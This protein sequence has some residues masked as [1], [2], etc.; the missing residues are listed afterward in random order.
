[1]IEQLI[2]W[3]QELFLYL[4]GLGTTVWDAFWLTYTA[5]LHW[6]PF[7]A[8]LAYL[9]FKRLN[10]KMFVLTLVV[11]TLMISFT[12]QGTNFFKDLFERPRPCYQDGVKEIMRL[13][14]NTCGG[15]NSY[16]SGHSSNAMSLAIFVGLVMRKKYKF[17]IYGMIVW[18]LLMGYSRIYIGVHYPLDVI[19]GFLF[20]GLAGLGF[21]KLDKYIQSRYTIVERDEEKI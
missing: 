7:Y 17:M 9:L 8:I 21:Y 15:R 12:D 16:F 6:I 1:M 13:V 20:G 4:N 19:S 2:Q 5:K 14:K 3:D 10:T 11:I 18:A